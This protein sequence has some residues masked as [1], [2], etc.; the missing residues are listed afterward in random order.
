MRKFIPVLGL[1]ILGCNPPTIPTI[2]N[3]N[4]NN[5]IFGSGNPNAVAPSG[6]NPVARVNISAPSQLKVNDSIRLDATPKDSNGNPRDAVRCDEASGIVWTYSS[7]TCR[8][9]GS[10]IFI[11][12][13]T[14]LA[15]GTCSLTA[16]VESV[17]GNASFQVVP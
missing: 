1:F 16:T 6:C 13:V 7:D 17:T 11:P 3:I 8:L 10:N 9:S 2:T 12:N 15:V 4:T 14:A 5:N